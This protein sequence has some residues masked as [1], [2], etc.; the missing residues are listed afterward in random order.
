MNKRPNRFIVEVR[1]GI[2]LFFN[3]VT[4]LADGWWWG[5]D[6]D[7]LQQGPFASSQAAVADACR[8]DERFKLVRWD[9]AALARDDRALR[10]TGHVV[11]IDTGGTLWAKTGERPARESWKTR[12]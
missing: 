9:R 5:S 12:H 1:G 7:P 6:A 10:P 4:E 11:L 3:R 2:V 8:G